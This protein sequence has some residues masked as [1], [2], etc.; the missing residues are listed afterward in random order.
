VCVSLSQL[1]ERGFA[2]HDGFSLLKFVL[3]HE[4]LRLMDFGVLLD[5]RSPDDDALSHE[6]AFT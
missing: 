6:Y 1:V 3:R 2:S 4:S 5:A